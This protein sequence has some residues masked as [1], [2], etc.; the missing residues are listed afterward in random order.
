MRKRTLLISFALLSILMVGCGKEEVKDIDNNQEAIEEVESID[1]PYDELRAESIKIE[2]L[3]EFTSIREIEDV[4]VSVE[5]ESIKMTV[6]DYKLSTLKPKDEYRE[7]FMELESE[8]LDEIAILNIMLEIENLSEDS[9]E[10][11]YAG[12]ILFTNTGEEVPVILEFFDEK[13]EDIFKISGKE[14]KK[15]ST[16]AILSSSAKD[17]KSFKLVYDD[18]EFDFK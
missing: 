9:L 2:E 13:H 17:I 7:F 15:G 5:N 6:T 11:D 4:D 8:D 10:I 12:G 16:S 14:V 1:V 3:G 18:L